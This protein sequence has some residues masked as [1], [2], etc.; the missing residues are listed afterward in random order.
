MKTYTRYED[1]PVHAR[2]I[3]LDYGDG[4]MGEWL[5]DELENAIEPVRLRE[6]DGTYSYF[7]LGDPLPL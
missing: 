3:G 6:P 4:S 2:Y 7:E 5:A 1:I